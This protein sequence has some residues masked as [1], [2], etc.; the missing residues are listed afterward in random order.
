MLVPEG[1][2]TEDGSFVAPRDDS[3][4]VHWG[5]EFDDPDDWKHLRRRWA[6][7]A[8]LL[9]DR[10]YGEGAGEDGGPTEF[11]AS[12]GCFAIVTLAQSRLLS[13][14]ERQPVWWKE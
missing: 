2:W 6:I 1:F 3:H 7:P 13:I 10:C 5:G 14:D 8:Y 11:C 12:C 4:P 9:H